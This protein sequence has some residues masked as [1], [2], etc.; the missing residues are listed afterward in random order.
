MG[1]IFDP[2][3]KIRQTSKIYE[4][5]KV[6]IVVL[7]VHFYLINFLEPVFYLNGILICLNTTSLTAGTMENL[8]IRYCLISG[9]LISGGC[10]IDQA[11]AR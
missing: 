1:R 8:K 11:P 3:Q 6:I 9:C 2:A 10:L 4:K 5:F 7:K